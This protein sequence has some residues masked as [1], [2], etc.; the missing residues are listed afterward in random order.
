MAYCCRNDRAYANLFVLWPLEWVQ[1][2]IMHTSY[3]MLT[4]Q[5]FWTLFHITDSS[6]VL[7]CSQSLFS[8]I[9][10][11]A[12]ILFLAVLA[13]CHSTLRHQLSLTQFETLHALLPHAI[14][15]SHCLH[16]LQPTSDEF[17]AVG[18]YLVLKICIT[19]QTCLDHC[20]QKYR[21]YIYE[22]F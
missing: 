22:Q 1:G 12:C 10:R 7:V 9:T 11:S 20:Y 6:H 4:A 18:T 17:F 2:S 19:V 21:S 13:V 8:S 14:D 3:E 15:S 5:S 16:R